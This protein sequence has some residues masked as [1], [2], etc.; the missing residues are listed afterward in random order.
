[1]LDV[2]AMCVGKVAKDRGTGCF[3]SGTVAKQWINMVTLPAVH[4]AKER[5]QPTNTL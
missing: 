1:M 5:N 3:R 4:V 2:P